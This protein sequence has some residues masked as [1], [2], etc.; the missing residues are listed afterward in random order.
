MKKL[1]E[2]PM[3]EGSK[4]YQVVHLDY[5]TEQLNYELVEERYKAKYVG[6]F[7]IKK[8][9]GEWLDSPVAIFY[10]EVPHPEGS[11]YFGV[12]NKHG[13]V[14]IVDGITATLPVWNG[15]WNVETNT[16]LYSAF[17]H[18]YQAVNGLMADGGQEYLRSSVHPVKR[19]KIIDGL[20]QIQ[21]D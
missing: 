17:H 12:L 6:E 1:H 9:S 4:D 2:L 8:P 16:V 15:V 20:I 19:F 3:N 14:V 18:D 5:L 11:N 7:S 13:T 10:T 21:E